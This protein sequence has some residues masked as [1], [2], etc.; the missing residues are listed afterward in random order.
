MRLDWEYAKRCHNM[1]TIQ[2]KKMLTEIP[3][4][5]TRPPFLIFFFFNLL[6]HVAVR[7]LDPGGQSLE[8]RN[9]QC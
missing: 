8:N 7:Y 9:S 4:I 5:K 2:N 3:R 1:S 6:F